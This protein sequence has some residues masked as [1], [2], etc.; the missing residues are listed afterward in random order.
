MLEARSDHQHGVDRLF[1][2]AVL[3][4]FRETRDSGLYALALSGLQG[5]VA[6]SRFQC[7]QLYVVELGNSKRRLL[8]QC[9]M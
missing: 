2:P 4:P 1:T 8:R 3:F 9:T 5:A 7:A 6:R